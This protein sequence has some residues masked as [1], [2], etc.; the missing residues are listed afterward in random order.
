[1]LACNKESCKDIAITADS[2]PFINLQFYNSENKSSAPLNT[3]SRGI[4]LRSLKVENGIEMAV[5]VID[6]MPEGCDFIYGVGL[7]IDN[8]VHLGISRKEGKLTTNLR[9]SPSKPIDDFDFNGVAIVGNIIQILVV[10]CIL[11]CVIGCCGVVVVYLCK[12]KKN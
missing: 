1:M 6:N 12:S 10:V 5:D 3:Y 4:Y 11:C 9:I 7:F 2:L 8:F